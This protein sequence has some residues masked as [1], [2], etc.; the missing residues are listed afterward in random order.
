MNPILAPLADLLTPFPG[1]SSLR[2][3][4]E[5]EVQ[6]AEKHI[7][8]KFPPLLREFFKTF[9]G[10]NLT[11]SHVHCITEQNI[12]TLF[13]CKGTDLDSVLVQFDNHEAYPAERTVP[14]AGDIFSNQFVW[15][16]NN[17]KV[18]FI[19]FDGFGKDTHVMSNSLEEFYRGILPEEE[20][21]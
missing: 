15:S 21:E 7:G 9:G 19:D 2:P 16:A 5:L 11:S 17:G 6:A 14:I 20:D 13:R 4:T 10:G 1:E 3:A 12:W 18:Y 8:L